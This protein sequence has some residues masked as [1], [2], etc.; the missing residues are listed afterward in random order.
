MARNKVV[1]YGETLIDL[2]GVSVTPESLAKGETALDKNGEPI[3]GT[4]T[5][6]AEMAQQDSLIEQIIAALNGKA[7]GGGSAPS[8]ISGIDLHDAST[9]LANTY[10]SD[11]TEKAY[12]AWTATDYIRL[13]DGKYYLA[14]STSVIDSKYCS[15]FNA[16]KGFVSSFSGVINCT[17]KNRP[18]FITGYDGYIRFS[19]TTAQIAALEFYEVVNFNWQAP[20]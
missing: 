15:R 14:Y 5:L 12:N 17:D 1:F 11:A 10:I 13:E 4:F 19:G 20:T 9:D 8:T 16:S 3:T 7:A 6:D 2:T 18:T